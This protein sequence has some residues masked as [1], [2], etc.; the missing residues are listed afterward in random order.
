MNS[1]P[2][3]TKVSLVLGRAVSSN[4]C[5]CQSVAAPKHQGKRTHVSILQPLL[6]PCR[7]LST[8]RKCLGQVQCHHS[9]ARLSF[10]LP[11]AAKRVC[12]MW[13][14]DRSPADR[15]PADRSP[16]VLIV[17]FKSRTLLSPVNP[18]NNQHIGETHHGFYPLT[19]KRRAPQ[20]R[21]TLG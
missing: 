10:L 19:D 3:G 20:A 1:L 9:L 7:L 13:N 16:P 2:S 21:R 6:F 5:F 15:S 8:P 11:Q 14:A 17:I 4:I 18:F 12:G